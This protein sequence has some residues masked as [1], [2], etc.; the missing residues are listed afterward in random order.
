VRAWAAAVA[1]LRNADCLLRVVVR[2]LTYLASEFCTKH[3]TEHA[4]SGGRDEGEAHDARGLK[5][6]DVFFGS[7]VLSVSQN[8]THAQMRAKSLGSANRFSALFEVA[9]RGIDRLMVDSWTKPLEQT[10]SNVQS[11]STGYLFGLSKLDS[12][13]CTFAPND[14]HATV[15][16]AAPPSWSHQHCSANTSITA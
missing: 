1:V 9:S 11:H 15:Q 5:R 8:K 14:D 2:E 12:S 4:S 7:A 16:F 13:K 10:I 3:T 6:E